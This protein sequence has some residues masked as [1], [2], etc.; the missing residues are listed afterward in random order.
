[1]DDKV[2]EGSILATIEN[3]TSCINAQRRKNKKKQKKKL[4]SYKEKPKT[5]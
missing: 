3:G 2:L 5:K 4:Q 1:M